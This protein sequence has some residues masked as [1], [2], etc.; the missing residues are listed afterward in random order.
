MLETATSMGN[1][2]QNE[3]EKNLETIQEIYDESTCW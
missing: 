1:Y 2:F 3:R